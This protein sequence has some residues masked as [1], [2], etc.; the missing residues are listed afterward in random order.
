MDGNNKTKEAL[1]VNSFVNL[2]IDQLKKIKTILFIKLTV[3]TLMQ[4]TSVN[5]N[6]LYNRVQ[7]TQEI[8]QEL[9]L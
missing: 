1:C 7:I 5:P 9:R 4:Y 2:K 6:G 8:C 3:V